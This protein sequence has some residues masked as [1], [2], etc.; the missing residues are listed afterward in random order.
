MT[1]KTGYEKEK[2]SA[3]KILRGVKKERLLVILGA[4]LIFSALFLISYNKLEDFRAE[5]AGKRM[6]AE[7]DPSLFNADSAKYFGNLALLEEKESSAGGGSSWGFDPESAAKFFEKYPCAGILS[8]PNLE[9]TLPVW[10][11]WNYDKLKSAPCVHFGSVE[12]EN[13]VIAAHNYSSH[14]GRL[15]ELEAG[16]EIR[17]WSR[18]GRCL[19]YSV[20]KVTVVK[21]SDVKKI[22]DSGYALVLYTC[23]PGGKSRV[24]V[25]CTLF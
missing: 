14:F 24:A 20:A 4:V 2:K 3:G 23:T 13:L 15:K 6:L 10:S 22:K 9:L 18:D 25:Y 19:D 12:D 1:K 11:E 21:P 8:I 17:F 7:L 5:Q 16:D